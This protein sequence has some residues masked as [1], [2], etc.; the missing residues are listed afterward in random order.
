MLPPFR[1]KPPTTPELSNPERIH[2]WL[3]QCLCESETTSVLVI[4]R[5][6]AGFPVQGPHQMYSI[7]LQNLVYWGVNEPQSIDLQAFPLPPGSG[8]F[9]AIYDRSRMSSSMWVCLWTSFI[10]VL[11]NLELIRESEQQQSETPTSIQEAKSGPS[12]SSQV[13]DSDEHKWRQASL[14]LKSQARLLNGNHL[15]YENEVSLLRIVRAA[16]KMLGLIEQN[17]QMK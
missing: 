12:R 5:Q 13:D 4:G 16:E 9:E 6:R 14:I 15:N 10:F 8:T 7:L 11:A 2:N 3:L 17:K 1:C